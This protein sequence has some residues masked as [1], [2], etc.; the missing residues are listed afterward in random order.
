MTKQRI[1][2]G[3]RIVSPDFYEHAPMKN[4][5]PCNNGLSNDLILRMLQNT[6]ENEND[7]RGY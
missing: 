3:R 2:Y 4:N 7:I 1:I 6:P 5:T